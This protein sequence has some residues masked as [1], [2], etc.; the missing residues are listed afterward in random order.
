MQV[1][2]REDEERVLSSGFNPVSIETDQTRSVWCPIGNQER[3]YEIKH[4][5]FLERQITL[6]CSPHT[7]PLV[8][9][10]LDVPIERDSHQNSSI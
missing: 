7:C 6:I 2:V 8:S 3:T 9:P 4:D 10:N 1:Y 5:A